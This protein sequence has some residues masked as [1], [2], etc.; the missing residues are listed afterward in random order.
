MF[1]SFY[2]LH[3]KSKCILVQLL[4]EYSYYSKHR[5]QRMR[6]LL[7]WKCL[8]EGEAYQRKHGISFNKILK[9]R[10][11]VSSFKLLRIL[12]YLF[13]DFLFHNNTIVGS[14]LTATWFLE[15]YENIKKI[16]KNIKNCLNKKCKSRKSVNKMYTYQG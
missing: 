9:K 10:R 8:L 16:S 6:D 13:Y 4:V 2:C 7:H 12:Q 11:V 15:I 1:L 3:T 14:R 5:T